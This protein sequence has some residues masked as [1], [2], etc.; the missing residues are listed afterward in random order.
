MKVLVIE[1]SRLL[2][3]AIG[4]MLVKAGYD[5]TTVGDGQRGLVLAREVRPDAVLLDM[6]LPVL[7]GT[8]V[9]E[10]LKRDPR[11]RTIPVIV[12]SGLSQKNERKLRTAGASAYIEKSSLDL[13]DESGELVSIVRQVLSETEI[14]ASPSRVSDVAELGV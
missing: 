1:D 2:R 12:L 10:G 8:A 11:T 3:L 5:V 7:E 4:R 14:E 13:E 6:M 9:L